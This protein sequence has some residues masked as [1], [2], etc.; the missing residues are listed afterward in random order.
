MNK[1]KRRTFRSKILSHIA[2]PLILIMAGVYAVNAWFSYLSTEKRL[3]HSLTQEVGH[4]AYRLQRL[5]EYA[6]ANTQGLADFIGFLSSKEDINDAEK[7]KHVLINRLQRN[8][9]FFGSAVAFKPNTFTT[10]KLFSPYVYRDG[11]DNSELH[12]LD[13]GVE[14]YDYTDG[15]WDWWS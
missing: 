2:L 6:Q 13:I 1:N 8:P 11:L 5:L 9:D 7:L 15:T 14:G 4:S 3:Y 10:R 12:Y